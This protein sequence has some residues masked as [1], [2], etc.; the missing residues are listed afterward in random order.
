MEISEAELRVVRA[1]ERLLR[2]ES[3]LLVR[4][5]NERTITHRLAV[6]LGQEFKGWH[7]DCE[8]NRDGYDPTL[9]EPGGIRAVRRST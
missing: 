5:L 8:Y 7:V 2:E 9:V 4:D 3:D 6:Q 1:V